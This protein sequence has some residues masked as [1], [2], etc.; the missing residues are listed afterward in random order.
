MFF[1][2]LDYILCFILALLVPQCSAS[3]LS[4][5]EISE[6]HGSP[7]Q[8]RSPTIPVH[9]CVRF[10]ASLTLGRERGPLTRSQQE[11]VQEGD[12]L[13]IDTLNCWLPS[14]LANLCAAS[15]LISKSDLPLDFFPRPSVYILARSFEFWSK[16]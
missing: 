7:T 12:N 3:S 11:I 14:C 15:L 13:R 10:L 1:S 8:A 9:L 6:S 5:S 4:S 2:T 16:D